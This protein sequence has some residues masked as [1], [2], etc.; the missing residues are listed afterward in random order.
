MANAQQAAPHALSHAEVDRSVPAPLSSE[1]HRDNSDG[2]SGS[3]GEGLPS[4]RCAVAK[5]AEHSTDPEARLDR[6]TGFSLGWCAFLVIQVGCV[7]P[8]SAT[9]HEAQIW[10]RV[11]FRC[12]RVRCLQHLIHLA[13]AGCA[14]LWRSLAVP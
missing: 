2:V 6:L 12:S 13:V 3:T 1:T 11:Y 10:R 8:V 4:G 7:R 14:L 5:Q 9:A